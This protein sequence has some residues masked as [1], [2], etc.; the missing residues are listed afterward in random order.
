MPGKKGKKQET[1]EEDDLEFL[2]AAAKANQSKKQEVKQEVKPDNH[3][4]ALEL[5]NLPE[6]PSVS[7]PNREFPEIEIQVYNENN[8]YR[9]TSAELKEIERLEYMSSVVPDLREAAEVHR[10][11]RHWAM[12]YIIK[13]GVNLYE[14]CQQIEEAVRRLTGYQPITR[15]LAFPCGCS[16]NNCAAHYTPNH[17]DGR[18]LKPDD[19]MKIDFGVNINGNI[20]DSAFTVCFDEK[21]KPL[22]DAAKEATNVGIRTAGI[23]VRLCDIGD[24]IEEVFN[25]SSYEINGKRYQIRPVSNLSGHLMKPYTIHAGK[26][27]PICRGGSAEK[28]E[29]GE[30]YACET[31]GTTGKGRVHDQGDNLSHYMVNPHPPT[32]RTVTQR[33]LLKTLQDNFSTLAFC[34]RF[35]DYIGEKKYQISLRQ[36]CECRAVIE[37]PSLSDVKGC[38]VAQFEHSFILLPTHK[39][40]LSRGDDY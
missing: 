33:K 11:V 26:S 37:Y 16:I 36:L 29:E 18:V 4:S 28:M 23:D 2:M 17:N 34:P 14:M 15:G 21:Y 22:L 35:I 32:P 40:V 9:T 27:V 10:R 1:N 39:E 20:I 19:V 13:P 12:Q 24:A 6:A 3:P 7:F 38:H 25:A 30:L 31:F 8:G 5:P